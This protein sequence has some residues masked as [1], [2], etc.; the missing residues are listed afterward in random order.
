MNHGGGDTEKE[1]A[2]S[3][4]ILAS[5]MNMPYMHAVQSLF[6]KSDRSKKAL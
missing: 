1:K 3:T 6:M 5:F 4:L 2:P